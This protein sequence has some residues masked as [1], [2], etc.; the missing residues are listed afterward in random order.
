MG[1][2][3]TF[4][5]FRYLAGWSMDLTLGVRMLVKSPGLTVIAVIALAVAFGAGATYLQFVNGMVRPSLSFAGGDRLI[6]IITRDL[7]KNALD[8]RNLHDYRA[9]REQLT[10]IENIGAW[11]DVVTDIETEDGRAEPADGARI[12]PSAFRLVPASP[13]MGRPLV[14]A[15]DSAASPPVAVIGEAL[16]ES[17]FNRD[18]MILGRTLTIAKITHTIVGVMPEA[19]G[20]PVNQNLWIPFRDDGSPVKRG[21]GPPISVM[22]RLAP[23]VTLDAAQAELAAVTRRAASADPLSNQRLQPETRTYVASLRS[24]L[25]V[26]MQMMALYMVN[27]VF[28]ALL[29]LCAAN[30]ATLVFGRTVTREAEITVRT[31]LGASRARVVS[32]LVAEAAVL[33]S[34]G[35]VAG[36]GFA[37]YALGWV[38][39]AWEQGQGSAMP[40][41]WSEQLTVETFLYTALLVIVAALII[42]GI[43]ALKAT[44]PQMQTRLKDAG[45]GSTMKFGGLWTSVIVLQVAFTVVFML[46]VVSLGWTIYTIAQQYNDV[47][48]ER[49][50]YLVAQFAPNTDRD[51][52]AATT[53]RDREEFLRRLRQ[54]PAVANATYTDLLPGSDSARPEYEFDKTVLSAQ[55]LAHRS[56]FFRDVQSSRPRRPEFHANGDRVGR[57]RRRGRRVVRALRA[58]RTLRCRPAGAR[59]ARQ[60]RAGRM[61]RN[62]R[63]HQRHLDVRA[64]DHPGCAALFADWRDPATAGHPRRALATRVS[65]RR[66]GPGGRGAA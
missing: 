5:S 19:F 51:P 25:D 53:Y 35:A 61:D 40:F 49:R 44:G 50:D 47:A 28:I 29:L 10:L 2:P 66:S 59:G 31:A 64:Q 26:S 16:W 33:A 18:P 42:G 1:P 9:W 48:F 22:G 56:R 4:L 54:A 39:R 58:W 55:G 11:Q 57:Q 41:W 45:A 21:E 37:R 23:G 34:V 52:D 6:G 62:H 24:A 3:R 20:F 32:Q 17:R 8:R 13:L 65:K 27:L 46:S 43:P 15:D 14:D 63:R 7:E 38:R 12:S 30:V 36:L 60:R